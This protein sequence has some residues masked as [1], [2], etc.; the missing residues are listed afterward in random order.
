M[1]KFLVLFLL[2]TFSFANEIKQIDLTQAK[3]EYKWGDSPFENNIPLWTND[4][5]NDSSWQKIDFPSNPENR[6]NQTNVWYRV[7]L[8][9]VLPNDPNL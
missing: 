2:I 9:D 5:E 3:W 8:P 4:K 6:N 1:Q 7:K